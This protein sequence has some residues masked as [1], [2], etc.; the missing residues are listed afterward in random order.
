VRSLAASI[1]SLGLL[2]P[3]VVDGNG[4]LVAGARRIA[5]VRALGWRDVPVRVVRDLADA[6]SAL[7]AVR[8]LR[9]VSAPMGLD[10]LH[11]S[12]GITAIFK[13]AVPMAQDRIPVQ[14]NPPTK[15]SQIGRAER[16]ATHNPH[17][18]TN[19][20][21]Y[22]LGT[23]TYLETAR[24]LHAHVMPYSHPWRNPDHE[25]QMVYDRRDCFVRENSMPTSST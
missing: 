25:R 6:A 19:G 24:D 10:W 14:V 16:A 13:I 9:T 17:I 22:Q 5:A 1:A 2:H 11:D 21:G 4:R 23:T 7:R 20:N 15:L 18:R 8:E 3:V 12:D